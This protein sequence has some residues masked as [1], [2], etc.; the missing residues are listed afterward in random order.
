MMRD[1]VLERYF[2]SIFDK[3]SDFFK[4][5]FENKEL[6]T[7]S[8]SSLITYNEAKGFLYKINDVPGIPNI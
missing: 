2:D 5:Y 7:L 8:V 6:I 4:D 1:K 3:K